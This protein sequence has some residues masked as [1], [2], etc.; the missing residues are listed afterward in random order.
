MGIV[1]LNMSMSL[2][3]FI[4]GPDDSREHGL[5]IGGDVLHEWIFGGPL[6]RPDLPD[7]FA[8]PVVAEIFEAAG[9][10]VMGRHSYE[11]TDGWGDD[12]PFHMPIFVVTHTAEAT[13]TKGDTSFTFVTEGPEAALAMAKEAAGGKNVHLHGAQVSQQLLAAGLV[14]E[15][16]VHLVPVLLS[17]G[18]RLFEHIGPDHIQLE[19]DRVLEDDGATHLRYRVV[20]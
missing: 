17:E 19:P 11:V 20:R 18:K 13:I 2:D 12:P 9:A 3:G 7:P 16:Q 5:G 10:L 14:D 8:N 1:T 4:T 15:V 6:D